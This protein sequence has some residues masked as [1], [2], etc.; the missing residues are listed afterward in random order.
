THGFLY[1]GDTYTTLNDPSGT[2]TTAWG[3]ND[4]GQIVGSYQAGNFPQ[5][6]VYSAGSYSTLAVGSS[7]SVNRS[8]SNNGHITGYYNNAS[9]NQ[10]GFLYRGGSYS[11]LAFPGA[12][13]TYPNGGN[14]AGQI[15]GEYNGP[16]YGSFL[17]SAGSFSALND[18]LAN[19]TQTTAL[20]INNLGQVVGYY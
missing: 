15:V 10:V 16:T 6:F 18:P 8:I 4:R 12:A 1:S 3:I 11:T 14:N 19:R 2:S 17:Y 5:N 20:D 9:S 13:L 7:W